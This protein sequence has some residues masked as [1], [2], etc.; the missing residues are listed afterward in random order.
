MTLPSN[1]HGRVGGVG[2]P[3]NRHPPA[4]KKRP[5]FSCQKS[6]EGKQMLQGEPHATTLPGLDV[7]NDIFNIHRVEKV[8]TTFPK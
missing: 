4:K 8:T 1:R 6:K 5:A 3:Q 7:T 2:K